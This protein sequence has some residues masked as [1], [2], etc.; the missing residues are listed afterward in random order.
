MP[1]L[2][3]NR[4]AAKRFKKTGSGKIKR[5][6][7]NSS[8]LFTKKSTKRKRRLRSSALVSKTDLKKVKKL[9]PY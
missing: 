4:G 1:K 7:S 3:T 8:H 2:K 5:R 6:K 9:I